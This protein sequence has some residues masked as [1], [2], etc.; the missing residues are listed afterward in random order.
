M[1]R[2]VDG[3]L[4]A[5][6]QSSYPR[7][8]LVRCVML[9][10][11]GDVH[12]AKRVYHAA[13]AATAGF[14]RDRAGGDDRALRI[15]HVLVQGLLHMCGCSPYGGQIT[16]AVQAAERVANGPDSDPLLR[17]IFSLGMCI[18][19]PRDDRVRRG[20]RVGGARTG[21]AGTG[22][23]LPGARRLPG[24]AGRHGWRGAAH[25]P[26]RTCYDRALKVARASHLRDAGAVMIGEV[27]AAELELERAAGM[28]RLDGTRVSPQLLGECSAWLD[29]YAAN[30]GV[31]AELELLRGGP[32]AASRSSRTR[33]STRGAPSGRR[34][35]GFCRRR[36]SVLL[37][38]EQVEEAGRAWRSTGCPSRWPSA[39][40]LRA[41]LAGGGDDRLHAAAAVRR[42]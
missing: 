32:S 4:T 2:A 24:R 27:L 42:P 31:G 25:A 21:G 7:T 13:A 1:L 38:G 18:R 10:A 15:D 41:E 17:G 29:I 26:A 20:R 8:A 9:A 36:G 34:W 33:A 23:A 19:P 40:S 22:L 35:R 30:T 11:T 28:P 3:L 14:T 5:E 39:P 16:E 37:A 6:V 12:G